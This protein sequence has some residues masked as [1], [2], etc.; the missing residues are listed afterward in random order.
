MRTLQLLEVDTSDAKP[1]IKWAGGK[2][3]L[4]NK[5]SH[6]LPPIK[7]ETNYHE[8]FLGSGAMFFHLKP[9]S[10][11]LC[12]C[13]LDVTNAFRVVRDNVEY[14]IQRLEALD[15]GHRTRSAEFYYEVRKQDP[16]EL[17]NVQRA[18]RFIYL[19]KTCYNGIYRVNSSGKFNVPIGRYKDPKIVDSKTLRTASVVL[20]HASI[21]QSD[22][23]KS[24][25]RVSKG[26]F[27]YLDPPYYGRFSS[28]HQNGFGRDEQKEL[29]E[30]FRKLHNRGAFLLM[31]NGTDEEIIKQYNAFNPVRLMSRVY[32][33]GKLEG[34]KN[35]QE[36]LIMNYDPKTGELLK[37]R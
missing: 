14:L 24:L 4:L 10:A 34:R 3:H 29:A 5:I 32:L 33:S 6:Y 16:K 21:R 7:E 31:S 25:Q 35:A 27:V 20:R 9:K 36:L 12:D 15:K 8:P 2:R 22:Y 26:D 28:Y 37:I 23:T 30:W 18:A 1:F 11:Y 13:L 17:D 19:N